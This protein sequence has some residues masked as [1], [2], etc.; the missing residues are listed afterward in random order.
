MF[1]NVT[2]RGLYA[3]QAE[4]VYFILERH[5]N[6]F[7]RVIDLRDDYMTAGASYRKLA[8]SVSPGLGAGGFMRRKKRIRVAIVKNRRPRILVAGLGNILLG[9]DGVGVHAVKRCGVAGR[10]SLRTIEVGCAVFDAL[11]DFEWADKILLVDA[12]K[13][14]GSPGSVYRVDLEGIDEGGVPASLHDLSAVHALHLTNRRPAPDVS[15]LGIEPEIIDYGLELSPVVE[16]ALPAVLRT[17][18]E[19][20]RE[21]TC[22]RRWRS[23]KA[24][25][26]GQ[27]PGRMSK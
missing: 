16:A 13:A 7:N 15:V 14:G 12:M 25:W 4:P 26:G 23:Q 18:K 5:Y 10:A 17:V 3:T 8:Y 21:W 20:V 27:N 24:A 1:E 9:D 22:Q 6:V 2:C 19:I 11:P